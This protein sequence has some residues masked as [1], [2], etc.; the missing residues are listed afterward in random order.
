MSFG[1]YPQLSI[2]TQQQYRAE[3][4]RNISTAESPGRW[5]LLVLSP[6]ENAAIDTEEKTVY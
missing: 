3:V 2:F 1:I 6:N 4:S 5:L